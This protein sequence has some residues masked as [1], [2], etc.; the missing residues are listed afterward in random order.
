MQDAKAVYTPMAINMF[1]SADDLHDNTTR[2][3]MSLCAN[4]PVLSYQS[5]VGML[6]W[7]MQDTRP[8]LACVMEAVE[9]C[10]TNSKCCHWDLAKCIIWYLK[11]TYNWIL[12]YNRSDV[13]MNM[14]FHG[15]TGTDWSGDNDTSSSISG[16]VFIT[17]KAA[18]GWSSKHQSMVALS[19]TESKYIGLANTEQHLTWLRSFCEELD[20]PQDGA[21]ELRCDNQVA[22]ILTKDPRFRARSKHIQCKYHFVRNGLVATGEA[23][24]LWYPTDDMVAD[25]FT[26]V[27]PHYKHMKFCHAMGLHPVSS[28][29]VR[30]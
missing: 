19:S 11:G 16:Y 30:R 8:D 9:W 7:A 27:L 13:S 3:H 1:L 5:V 23:A 20:K 21:T 28:G 26:K 6:M 17:N 22:I 18:I 2:M 14:T 15:Y 10:S 24:V 25:I 29:S 12:V 4:G